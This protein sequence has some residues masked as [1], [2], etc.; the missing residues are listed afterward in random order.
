MLG[1]S[2]LLTTTCIVA[3]EQEKA[4]TP[5]NPPKPA[6]S[7]KSKVKPQITDAV[8]RPAPKTGKT[9]DENKNNATVF[10]GDGRK[11]PFYEGRDVAKPNG[12]DEKSKASDKNATKRDRPKDIPN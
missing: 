1:L 4:K 6:P 12:R 9:E 5:S 11:N 3:Q 10:K 2:M 7:A 8:T